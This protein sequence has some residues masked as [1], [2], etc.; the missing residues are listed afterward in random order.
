MEV[1][2][3]RLQFLLFSLLHLIAN[4]KFRDSQR[5][6]HG[7]TFAWIGNGIPGQSRSNRNGWQP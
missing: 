5:H 1:F 3:I 2:S 6:G 4:F 7:L